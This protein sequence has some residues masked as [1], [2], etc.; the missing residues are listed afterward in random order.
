MKKREMTTVLPRGGPGGSNLVCECGGRLRT[1]IATSYDFSGYVGFPVALRN[2]PILR[3]SKCAGE[4]I[5]GG[6]INI[7]L[8]VIV[9]E[10]T[11]SP[12]RLSS[13]EARFLRRILG[14][15][16]QEL[17]D[18]MGIARETVAKWECG[19]SISPQHDLIL[20]VIV[21]TP[22]IVAEP[23]FVPKPLMAD[24]LGRMQAVRTGP[25][26]PLGAIDLAPYNLKK[27]KSNWNTSGGAVAL[28]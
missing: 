11:K 19:D 2:V 20:R 4:T 15:T 21:L 23:A 28:G 25:P 10:I 9:L 16:Q 26:S 14:I 1:E 3:C 5:D 6:I 17:S 7:L 8:K 13:D 27:R 22:I 18:R 24:L 12:G